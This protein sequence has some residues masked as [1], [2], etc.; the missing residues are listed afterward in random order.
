MRNRWEASDCLKKRLA[1]AGYNLQ[2]A[3]SGW[4]EMARVFRECRVCVDARSVIDPR[5]YSFF[6][7]Q[8]IED[9]GDVVFY[10]NARGL[11]VARGVFSDSC[12]SDSGVELK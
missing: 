8:F 6:F 7:M 10:K 11:A 9:H 1:E 4:G 5:L 2:G 3:P 12:V